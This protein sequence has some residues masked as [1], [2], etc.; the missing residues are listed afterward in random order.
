M[1]DRSGLSGSTCTLTMHALGS[2]ACAT[3]DGSITTAHLLHPASHQANHPAQP[4][5]RRP[6]TALGNVGHPGDPSAALKTCDGCSCFPAHIVQGAW[7]S[8]PAVEAQC[9]S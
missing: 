4:G 3:S 9:R 8:G 1:N 7:A 2:C 5:Q 6:L